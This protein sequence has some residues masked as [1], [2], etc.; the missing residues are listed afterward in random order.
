MRVLTDTSQAKPKINKNLF[1]FRKL[2]WCH[3][4]RTFYSVFS[5]DMKRIVSSHFFFTMKVE[6]GWK[7]VVLFVSLILSTEVKARS[8]ISD[9]VV[10]SDC[11]FE[12]SK[13]SG[14]IQSPN[15][16]LD[17]PVNKVCKWTIIAPI[18]DHIV[19]QFISPFSVEPGSTRGVCDRDFVEVFDGPTSRGE[20]YCNSN[21]RVPEEKIVSNTNVLHVVLKSGNRTKLGRG[22]FHAKYRRKPCSKILTGSGGSFGSPNFPTLPYPADKECIWE[23]EAPKGK[24]IELYIPYFKMNTDSDCHFDFLNVKDGNN[25]SSKQLGHFCH[26]EDR[27]PYPTFPI[28]STGSSMYVQFKSLQG[29]VSQGYGFHAYYKTVDHCHGSL[30]GKSVSFT[31]PGFPGQSGPGEECDWS[32]EASPGKSVM[33]TFQT[34]D[35]TKHFNPQSESGEICTD[36]YVKVY[37]G[38]NDLTLENSLGT[39]CNAKPVPNVILSTTNKM[40]VKL[41]R[42]SQNIGKGF[43]AT[44]FEVDPYNI[45]EGCTE[46]SHDLVFKCRNGRFIQCQWKCDSADDCGDNS[47]EINCIKADSVPEK[48]KRHESIQSYIIIILSITGSAVAIVCVAFIVDRLRRKRHAHSRNRRGRRRRSRRPRITLPDEAP[49]TD[50]PSTPPP[51]YEVA[52]SSVCSMG[53]FP[54]AGHSTIVT[55]HTVAVGSDI[56]TEI[57]PNEG[58]TSTGSL[59]NSV[60]PELSPEQQS[61]VSSE[62]PLTTP[63]QQSN[64][65]NE[66]LNVP[67]VGFSGVHL[68]LAAEMTTETGSVE[69]EG[70]AIISESPP[71]SDS[72]PLIS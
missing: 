47:D 57:V 7:A 19:L 2:L 37:D 23:I 24:V 51:S 18:N 62:R 8:S 53:Q 40:F 39:Y 27:K 34:F 5:V 42:T 71:A 13:S 17:Y 69:A 6:I 41:R 50:D 63:P 36:N 4:K 25:S 11:H 30:Q 67:E 35:I 44:Y 10:D 3:D 15:F 45:Y 20:R 66:T 21:G 56:V 28:R 9:F 29:A 52:V 33:L 60:M 61:H 14:E 70:T 65:P 59:E 31:S 55:S 1:A 68:N 26:A 54:C 49:L 58:G 64:R 48:Q 22:L 38:N 16:P 32:I 43:Y 72:T 12:Y 46:K